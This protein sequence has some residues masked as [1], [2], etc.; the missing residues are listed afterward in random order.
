MQRFHLAKTSTLVF[1]LFLLTVACH[2]SGPQST[3]RMADLHTT[4]QLVS[5]FY[6]LEAGAWRWTGKDFKVLLKVPESASQK[7]GVLT[8]QG[9]LPE[10]ELRNGPVTISASVGGAPLQPETFS[11]QGELIYRVD[12]PAAA[13]RSPKIIANFTVDKVFQI[14][15]DKRQLGIV[16]S[17]FSL[18]AK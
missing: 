2:K 13:L 14:P 6:Q 3:V 11:K 5:G 10:A 18:R 1:S 12:V 9:S 17:V 8:L 16:A 4:R 7:G 15:E